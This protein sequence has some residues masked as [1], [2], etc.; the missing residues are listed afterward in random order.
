VTERNAELARRWFEEVWNQRNDATVRELLA[1]GAP[2]HMEGVEIVGP[3]QFLSA[4]A[5]LLDAFPDIRVTVEATIENGDDVVVRWS[6]RGTH[7]G[8]GLGIPASRKP[9]SFRGMS[10]MHF[11]NGQVVE[12]WDA[13]N[14]GK[15]LQELT[16]PIK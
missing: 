1:P 16:A 14:Q 15:L 4:R 7:Q 9:A 12:G 5:A 10:W 13:W 11:A 8:D 6:A 3:E 2:G